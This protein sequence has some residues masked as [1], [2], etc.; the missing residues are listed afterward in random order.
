MTSITA[1]PL[2]TRPPGGAP[3]VAGIRRTWRRIDPRYLQIF[4]LGALLIYGMASGLLNQTAVNAAA[5]AAGA[6]VAQAIGSAMIATRARL[7][8]PLITTLSLCL[9]LRADAP[10]AMALAGAIGVGSKF[11]FRWGD[12]HIF[13]PAN[14]GVV[15]MLLLGATALPGVAWSSP[16]QWGSA[17][18]LAVALAGAGFLVT[19]RA[20]RTDAA[21]VFFLTFAGL[22]CARALYLGDP[23]TIPFHRLQNGAFVL[24]AFFMITDPMTTPNGRWSRALFSVLVAVLAHVLTF[25]FFIVDGIFY[26]L[27]AA[28]LVRPLIEAFEPAKNYQWPLDACRAAQKPN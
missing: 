18:L 26:A 21:L 16:G 27:A 3:V 12:R 20:A 8:S 23:L 15:A 14:A 1:T 2:E 22:A 4:S 7:L 5:A 17:F 19:A 24:F 9:L 28:C 6:F 11:A 13:N 25:N 10:W